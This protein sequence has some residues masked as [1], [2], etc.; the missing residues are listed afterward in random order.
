MLTRDYLAKGLTGMARSLHGRWGEPQWVA[1][2]MGA[3]VLAAWYFQN[4][5]ELDASAAA[6]LKVQVDKL[7]EQQPDFF[8]PFKPAAAVPALL[9]EIPRALEP[10]IQNPD[11][12]GHNVIF[13]ML[14]T[15]ALKESPEL[16]T[17]E[18]VEGIRQLIAQFN[19]PSYS[20][21]SV[22]SGDGTPEYGGPQDV[23]DATLREFVGME[24]IYYG[25]Q[26][27][28]GHLLTH[29]QALIEWEELGY[30]DLARRGYLGHRLN[31]KDVRSKYHELRAGPVP[32]PRA[33]AAPASTLT[34]A[35]WEGDIERGTWAAGHV[36]KYPYTLYNLT[37]RTSDGRLRAEAERQLGH[38]LT[39]DT[40]TR[41]LF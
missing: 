22:E 36:F 27:G 33:A 14:A 38:L 31:L 25:W 11:T 29:A 28:P 16:I 9:D 19:R 17:P 35:F 30:R 7:I 4:E 32:P 6:A 12:A 40:V 39:R 15:K 20:K 13:A 10:S 1:G 18:I 5:N 41:S 21:I 3:A 2:H 23:L 26:G 24:D 8:V 37:R 34:S